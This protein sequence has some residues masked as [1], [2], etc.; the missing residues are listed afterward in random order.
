MDILGLPRGYQ[1]PLKTQ[2]LPGVFR[3]LQG[4]LGNQELLEADIG[5]PFII[6]NQMDS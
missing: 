4:P 3:N 6:K 1:G 2:E 5:S